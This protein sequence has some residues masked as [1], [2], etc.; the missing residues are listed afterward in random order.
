MVCISKTS[1]QKLIKSEKALFSDGA[2]LIISFVIWFI[3]VADCGIKTLGL[4]SVLNDLT[5]APFSKT[6]APISTILSK[7]ELSP[8]VSTSNA[9]NLSFILEI[10]SSSTKS[11]YV[12]TRPLFSGED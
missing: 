12:R 1:P 4:T 2:V 11:S 9:I 6:T 7:A 8:V 3:A 5:G 10:S